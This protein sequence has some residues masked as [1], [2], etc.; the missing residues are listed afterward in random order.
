M[1]IKEPITWEINLEQFKNP[2][3]SVKIR[4]PNYLVPLCMRSFDL[5]Q[6]LLEDLRLVQGVAQRV[7]AEMPAVKVARAER[8]LGRLRPGNPAHPH[9]QRLDIQRRVPERVAPQRAV[10]II[11]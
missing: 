8:A 4:V 7:V 1:R 2:C 9:V 5:R 10:E 3:L 6:Q 11:S